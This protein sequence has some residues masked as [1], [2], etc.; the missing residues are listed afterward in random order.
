MKK[1][2]R[3]CKETG[4]R[5]WISWVAH[6][7]KPL[8]VEHVPNM[9]EVEVSCQLEHYR[10]KSTDWLFSYLMVGTHDSVMLR[11]QATSYLCFVKPDSSRSILTLV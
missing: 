11:V 7:Y 8:N 1:S 3:L 6:G 10:T 9:L 4:T 2:S 5:D